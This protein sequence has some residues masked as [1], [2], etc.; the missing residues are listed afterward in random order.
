[1]T[2]TEITRP[3]ATKTLLRGLSVLEVIAS[4]PQGLRA[5]EV[6]E[7]TELDRATV[8]RLVSTL[9]QAGYL[10]L[11]DNRYFLTE[12]I[13]RLMNDHPVHS[14]LKTLARP[15]IETLCRD[16][17]EAVH[18][19]VLQGGEIVFIDHIGSTQQVRAELPLTPSAAHLTAIGRAILAFLPPREQSEVLDQSLGLT[20]GM[21][22]AM[23]RSAIVDDLRLT[24]RRGWATI[25]RDDDV[26]RV[27]APLH[28]DR[29]HAFAGLSISGPAYRLTDKTEALAASCNDAAAQI[30]DAISAART[31]RPT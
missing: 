7:R 8:S 19:G 5:S 16:S 12:R 22:T 24:A 10:T 21:A 1:M 31:I 18:L 6:A 30:N 23:E 14:E 2:G 4:Q 3:P 29:G 17:S 25:D 13:S 15:F 28:D 11:D 20:G 27:A 26:L 9:C